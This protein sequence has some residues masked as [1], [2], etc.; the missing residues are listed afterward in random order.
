M[1]SDVAANVDND[2]AANVDD[3]VA[4]YVDNDKA[5]NVDDD[6]ATNVDDDVAAYMALMM[7][8]AGALSSSRCFVSHTSFSLSLDDK[9]LGGN[10]GLACDDVDVV[11]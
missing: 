7:A 11:L 9:T 2:V 6:M 3:D 8:R 10:G 4:V 1:D 5:T